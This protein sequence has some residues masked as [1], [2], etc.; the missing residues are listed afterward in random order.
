MKHVLVVIKDEDCGRLYE[1]SSKGFKITYFGVLSSEQALD[2]I[3]INKP[4]ILFISAELD[5]D[6][7][8]LSCQN[9]MVI[10]EQNI[11]LLLNPDDLKINSMN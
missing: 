10:T 7:Q 11:D 5:I 4:D 3:D 9:V 2:L 1:N 8:S 6:S